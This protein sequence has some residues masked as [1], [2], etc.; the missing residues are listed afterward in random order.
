MK[1]QDSKKMRSLYEQ[2]LISGQS[3]SFFSNKCGLRLSTFN[4]WIKK[5]QSVD[6]PSTTSGKGFSQL[7][8]QEPLPV[9][10]S[11][12]VAIINF[13]SGI[14]VELCFPVSALYLKELTE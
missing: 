2:W 8:V 12:A 4:Y 6:D 11:Q 10:S 5:F 1:Q 13:P 9:G 14:K 3:K 7:A